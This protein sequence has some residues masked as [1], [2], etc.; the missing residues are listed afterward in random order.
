MQNPTL[1]ALRAC[2]LAAVLAFLVGS[3]GAQATAIFGFDGSPGPTGDAT[4]TGTSYLLTDHYGGTWHDAEKNSVNTEDDLMCWAAQASNLLTWTRW[5]NVA[6]MTNTDE[7]F[8]YFQDHWTDEGGNSYFGLDWWFDGTN[9]M[10]GEPDWSQVDVPG[11][12][13]YLDRDIADYRHW[14]SDDPSALATVDTYIRNG[15]ATGLSIA[16]P[17]GHAITS[18]GFNF[19]ETK[20]GTDYYVG[21]WLTDSDD[22]KSGSPPRPDRLR[23]YEVSYNTGAWY[24]QDYYGS[25]SWYISEVIG[26]AAIPE[27]TTALLLACGLAGL[28]AVVRRRSLR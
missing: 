7:V 19:D 8:V 20:T 10:Q 11:G 13:F 21:L 4:P 3:D 6:G 15:W 14:S 16:G 27:P 2:C 28:A 22:D 5:G 9:D 23:Y 24:L 12:G 17:G 25:N 1:G 26:L 18:W